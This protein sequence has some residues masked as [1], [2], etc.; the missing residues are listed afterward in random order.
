MPCFG[1]QEHFEHIP[2]A[3]DRAR[4]RRSISLHHFFAKSGI[5]LNFERFS[6]LCQTDQDLPSIALTLFTRDQVS[7]LQ[8][9][10]HP[11]Q[12]L[13]RDAQ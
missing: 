2:K 7:F 1:R 13:L 6:I 10:Q 8:F 4:A 12:R 11:A 3:A 9:A 5:K